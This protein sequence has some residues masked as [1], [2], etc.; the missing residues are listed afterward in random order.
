VKQYLASVPRRLTTTSYAVLGLLAVRPWNAYELANQSQRSLRYAWPTSPTHLY[1]EPK[2]LVAAGLATAS[3]K[4]AGPTRTRTE[5]AITPAGRRALRQWLAT[6]AAP[7]EVH[8][9]AMLRVGFADQ[10]TAA[11]LDATLA[12]Q[13]AKIRSLLAEGAEQLRGYLEDGGPFPERLHLIT[14]AT[15]F[16]A[17][18]LELELDWLATAR[19]ELATWSSTRGVGLT[20]PAARRLRA[21]LA[22]IERRLGTAGGRP[23]HRPQ[24]AAA[25]SEGFEPP[26]F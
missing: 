4:P 20:P 1:E 2:R 24:Q 3:S 15:D 11:A 22:R 6:P 16:H 12:D 23:R 8:H 25:R 7:P 10:S 14:L 18:L 5:Y 26:T 21:T 17:R 13:E 9:E 19:A